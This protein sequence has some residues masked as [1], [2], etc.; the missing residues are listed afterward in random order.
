MGDSRGTGGGVGEKEHWVCSKLPGPGQVWDDYICQWVISGPASGPPTKTILIDI[1][2]RAGRDF[3]DP[4]MR[5][6]RTTEE[7]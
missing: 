3:Q 7:K 5:M 6:L 4:L 1:A 2:L